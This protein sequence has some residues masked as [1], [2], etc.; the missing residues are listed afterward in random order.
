MYIQHGC[1]CFTLY[2]TRASRRT[3]AFIPSPGEYHKEGITYRR[4]ASLS[5]VI[6]CP[7][8]KR[9]EADG[10]SAFNR[11]VSGRPSPPPSSVRAAAE[12]LS[13][14]L[15]FIGSLQKPLEQVKPAFRNRPMA[16]AG[17]GGGGGGRGGGAAA[18]RR[19]SNGRPEK[20]G[21]ET[22]EERE[23]FN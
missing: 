23:A 18:C 15:P 3:R 20:A 10:L 12:S 5:Q 19:E 13:E 9:V 7:G 6:N 8:R 11:G 16:G 4:P 14:G 2:T 22:N 1:L 21:G 17:S